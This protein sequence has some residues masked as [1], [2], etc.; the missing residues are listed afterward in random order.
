MFPATVQSITL[1][2]VA[3]EA[4]AW[5]LRIASRIEGQPWPV[6]GWEHY[7]CLSR[8]ELLDVIAEEVARR[9]FVL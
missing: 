7:E 1:G 2:A 4:G 6:D 8:V 5:H 3:D 9:L